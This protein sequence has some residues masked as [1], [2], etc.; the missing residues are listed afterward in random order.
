[1]EKLC[2]PPVFV[3]LKAKMMLFQQG[4]R[5]PAGEVFLRGAEWHVRLID[6]NYQNEIELDCG[7]NLSSS[8]YL[9]YYFC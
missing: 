8:D 6:A 4:G 5:Y 3:I 2:I 1:M 7:S 9:K